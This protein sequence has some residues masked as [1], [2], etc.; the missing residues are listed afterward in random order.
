MQQTLG[1][2][3]K[4][5]VFSNTFGALPSLDLPDL[6]ELRPLDDEPQDT[7][8]PAPANTSDDAPAN[9]TA[10][11]VPEDDDEDPKDRYA[12]H[13]LHYARSV[14]PLDAFYSIRLTWHVLLLHA[15]S[16]CSTAASRSQAG[17]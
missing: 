8:D 13:P 2:L 15:F 16:Q 9:T 17:A 3:T 5:A 1:K 4:Y 14:I 12:D 6:D 10:V 11:A 7:S